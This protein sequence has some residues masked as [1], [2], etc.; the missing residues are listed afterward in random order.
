MAVVYIITVFND[1]ELFVISLDNHFE[2][3]L[4]TCTTH[5]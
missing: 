1:I 2:T 4:F 5:I 3:E